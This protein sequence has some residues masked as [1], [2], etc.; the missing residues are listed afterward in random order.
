M[1]KL[2]ALMASFAMMLSLAACGS[3]GTPSDTLVVGCEELSGTF[4]P[5]YYSSA[6]DAYVV[7]L[8]YD[9]LLAYNYDSELK[10]E[11]AAEMPTVSEDG[12]D[13][14]FKLQKGIK[15]SN[16]EKLTAKDVEFTFKVLADPSYTG[17]YG[18]A[19]Q[20]LVGYN[21][22]SA[23]ETTEFPGIEVVDD[24]TITFHFA[25]GYRTN[26]TDVSTMGIMS[27]AEFKDFKVGDTKAVEKAT[28]KPVG[29]GP[30]VLD[31]WEK[32]TG[33]VMTKNENYWGKG[34]KIEKV[35]IKPVEMTTDYQELEKGNID[36]LPGMIEPTKVGPASVNEDIAAS[37]YPRAGE[38]YIMINASEQAGATQDKA[39]RQALMFAFDRE[40]FVNS[41]FECEELGE[42]I[43]YVPTTMQN[44]VS[45]LS[46]VVTGKTPV[47]GLETYKYDIEKA[48]A[49]LDEAGWVV[50]ADGIR[51]KD[52][53]KLTVK[54]MAI[55]DHD[56][57]NT[58]VPMWTESWGEQ[59]GMDLKVATVDFNTLVA[60]V[61]HDTGLS[62]WNV[63]F[64][65]TSFTGADLDSIYSTFHSSQA[66]D[67]GD[68]YARLVD[69]EL[70]ALL[71][72]AK[73]VK[74]DDNV[75]A[76]YSEIAKKVN[77]DAVQMP[78]YGNTYFDLYKKDKIKG[79]KTS[80]LYD[81]TSAIQNATL[82]D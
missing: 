78:V 20:N 76:T 21:E 25:E 73:L 65:A 41:Y 70:D 13:I 8:V 69:P 38:G 17:R 31:S 62:E 66:I 3:S 18:P 23:G 56:I 36:Y 48:K 12:K 1:K 10:P 54:V 49:L 14:T 68:N 22:Y 42:T 79:L 7:N 29:T 60:T 45:I 26:L 58:L 61:S 51:E 57:C 6:Y 77:D 46:D 15:F 80:P 67:G 2:F 39:V 64:M 37:T 75:I 50:G 47:E 35:I 53:Q 24:Q 82:A 43:A 44:P 30:Y 5:A 32:A 16:G 28:S 19:V 11:L 4:S 9:Q 52:G 34:Y 27:S 81:W 40:K 63:F 33:A 55:E 74:G 71:D 72:T 59:L